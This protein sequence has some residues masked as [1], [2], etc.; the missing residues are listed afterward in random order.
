MDITSMNQCIAS[1]LPTFARDTGRGALK[2]FFACGYEHFC[3]QLYRD[4]VER[5]RSVY[6]LLQADKPTKIYLD[7]DH[8]C[9]KDRDEFHKSTT[10]FVKHMYGVLLER[11]GKADVP[12]YVLDAGT[13][14]KLSL[15]VI[16]ECFLA[17]IP[18]VKNFVQ[19][20]LDQCPCAYL[21]NKVYTRNR[22]FR[23]LYSKKHGN[24]PESSLRVKG[25]PLD[26]PY[27][28][29]AVFKT[30]IQ[31]MLTPHYVGPFSTIK[32]ELAHGVSFIMLSDTRNG[33]GQGYVG[34]SICR[35][36]PTGFHKLVD[37]MGGVVLSTKENENFISCIVGSKSCPWK[38]SPHKNNNQYFTVCKSN[39]RGFFQ[40]ADQDCTDTAYD[41]V[42]VSFLWRKDMLI[43]TNLFG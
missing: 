21:D 16:F 7:F 34:G 4:G 40:C 11:T 35:S 32:N 15:H 22:L 38:G 14:V 27:D 13:D 29:M 18:T 36:L 26:S 42:D 19:Y 17:D 2:S 28:P 10:K 20:V 5:Y 30:M 39:L 12:F 41:H 33:G 25:T 6:E 8:G 1:G 9:V 31:A 37:T 24:S 3:L 43:N 23:L